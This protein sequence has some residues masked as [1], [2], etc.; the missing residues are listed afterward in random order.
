MW[1]IQLNYRV[2][3]NK[4]FIFKHPLFN[5]IERDGLTEDC[6]I[7]LLDEKGEVIADFENAKFAFGRFL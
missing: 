3:L 4:D 2:K 1:V 7:Q 5:L 6:D